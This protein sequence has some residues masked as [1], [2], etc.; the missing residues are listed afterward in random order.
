M[1]L[2]TRQATSLVRCQAG[3]LETAYCILRY[4]VHPSIHANAPEHPHQLVADGAAGL[5]L[6]PPPQ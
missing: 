6:P 4:V 2:S 5:L 1:T 3:Q